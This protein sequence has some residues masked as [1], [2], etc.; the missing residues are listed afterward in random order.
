M[1]FY[2]SVHNM[3]QYLKDILFKSWAHSFQEVVF[4]EIN[5]ERF[6]ILYSKKPSRPNSPVNV[7][8]GALLLKEIFDHTDEELL[9]QIYFN[10][11]YQY[12]L[13]LTSEEKPPVSINTFTNFRKRVYSYY[14][15]TGIDLIQQEMESLADVI[16][17]SL[18]IENE[19]VRIDSFMVSSSCRNLSRIELVYTVNYQFVK[20]LAESYNH[21][22]PEE[23]K[24]YLEE[25]H[26]NETIYQTKNSETETKLEHLLKQSKAL[27]D[28]GLE[29]G[30]EVT[31]TEEFKLLK[32]MLGE[33]TKDDDDFDNIE[34]KENKDISPESLQNPSDPDATYRFKYDDNQGYVANIME[35]FDD[36]NSV[37]K[38]YDYQ[39]NIHS[40][41]KFCEKTIDKVGNDNSVDPDNKEQDQ[42]FNL[43]Q[44]FIDGTYYSFALAKKAISKGIM[45][46]PGE[47]TGRKPSS[48]KMSYYNSFK[49]DETKEAITECA[50]GN[51]PIYTEK[52][53]DTNTYYALF[54]KEECNNC[55][56][57]EECRIVQ[58]KDVNSVSITEKRYQT[59][60]LREK[61]GTDEYAEL[62]NQRAAIEGIPS[63]FRR[64]YNVDYMPVRGLVRSKIWFGFK[65]GA[66]NIKKLFKG[67]KAAA[68]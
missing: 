14:R 30:K 4:P 51:K 41:Q 47:L 16:A 63:V 28:A 8:I 53:D 1:S 3:P 33:Q 12:A 23:C 39:Q 6:E 24:V 18:E 10:Q 49:I 26:K 48:D 2:D 62:T 32:R 5:E 21:L 7:I 37:I 9:G 25:G 50:N 17:D 38:G 42:D 61:M 44:A 34:P 59:D 27:Y 52:N 29:S 56:Y 11:R 19:K 66:Y 43:I 67:L 31:E 22:L 65:V 20:I 35:T 46:I 36:N 54:E 60:K 55:P 68:I 64:K 45:L 40:D 13:R 57:Q 58:N 15:Q